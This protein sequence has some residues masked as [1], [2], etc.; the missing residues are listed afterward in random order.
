MG[1][2]QYLG[3]GLAIIGWILLIIGREA[4]KKKFMIAGILLFGQLFLVGI[5]TVVL[6]RIATYRARIEVLDFL[7]KEELIVKFGEIE[8]DSLASD[9]IIRDLRRIR[10]VATHHSSPIGNQ[11]LIIKSKS[12]SINLEIATDSENPNEFWVFFNKYSSIDDVG[13]FYK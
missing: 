1:Y 13:H 7:A 5:S 3:F 11:Q 4:K 6:R 8:K 10:H 12:E 9:S 2:L